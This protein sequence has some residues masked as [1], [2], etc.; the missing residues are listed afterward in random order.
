MNQNFCE[1]DKYFQDQHIYWYWLI[2]KINQFSNVSIFQ[3]ILNLLNIKIFISFPFYISF[4]IPNNRLNDK[5]KNSDLP[6]CNY[7]LVRH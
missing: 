2:S 5:I 3:I 1:R 6:G 4:L 7:K